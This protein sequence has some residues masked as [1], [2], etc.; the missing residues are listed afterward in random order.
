MSDKLQSY[1]DR[2]ERLEEE[3]KAINGDVKDIY[4]EV[5]SNGYNP[6]ALRRIVAERRKTPDPQLEADMDAYR[7]A[8]GMAVNDVKAGDS[9]RK[10]ATKHGV[11][12][13]TLQRAVPRKSD[14]TVRHDPETGEITETPASG[15]PAGGGTGTAET[16]G[17]PAPAAA[18]PSSGGKPSDLAS[19]T[20]EA[21]VSE[22]S[23]VLTG[24]DAGTTGIASL[25]PSLTD[26]ASRCE[27]GP[28]DLTIPTFL[29]CR[30]QATA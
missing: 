12:K 14:G 29:D 11:S 4:S 10:A 22:G 8:L 24:D 26:V 28:L 23:S 21:T 7:V 9:L 16:Q 2:I 1:V 20:L 27:P 25:G 5:K 19:Q 18:N 17:S 30:K 6:K 13:S 15:C 3:R